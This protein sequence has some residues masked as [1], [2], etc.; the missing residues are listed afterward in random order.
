MRLGGISLQ[1]SETFGE[2]VIAKTDTEI[3]EG[4]FALF[5]ER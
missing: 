5:D 2:M 3:D 1:Q 4:Q